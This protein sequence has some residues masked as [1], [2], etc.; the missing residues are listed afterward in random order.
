MVYYLIN[1]VGEDWSPGGGEP[2]SSY[3]VINLVPY[4][5]KVGLVAKVGGAILLPGVRVE[6]NLVC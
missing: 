2:P 1:F 5:K 4:F 6:P 3:K